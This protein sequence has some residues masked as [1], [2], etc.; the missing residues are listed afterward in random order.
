[1]GTL[2]SWY[3]LVSQAGCSYQLLLW[4]DRNPARN[5]RPRDTRSSSVWTRHCQ[6]EMGGRLKKMSFLTMAEIRGETKRILLRTWRWVWCFFDRSSK[7][8]KLCNSWLISFHPPTSPNCPELLL[9]IVIYVS[10]YM[11]EQFK[12]YYWWRQ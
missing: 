7:I 10:A 3:L 9:E 2:I 12:K 11:Q 5:E 8:Y 6:H 4:N 1:M